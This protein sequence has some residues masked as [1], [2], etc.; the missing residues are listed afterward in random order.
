MPNPLKK[1]N[2]SEKLSEQYKAKGR[3]LMKTEIMSLVRQLAPE[4][5]NDPLF[6]LFYGFLAYVRTYYNVAEVVRAIA[7]IKSVRET[8]VINNYSALSIFT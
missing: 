7:I 8:G 1:I 3:E 2:V 4:L 5:E 6:P